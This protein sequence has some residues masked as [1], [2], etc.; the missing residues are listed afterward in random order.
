M[1]MFSVNSVSFLTSTGL[2]SWLEIIPR[3]INQSLVLITRC[4]IIPW[5][6]W[7]PE[8]CGRNVFEQRW[9]TS[10][11]M[12]NTQDTKPSSTEG[13]HQETRTASILSNQP[14]SF[15]LFSLPRNFTLNFFSHF[16]LN[17]SKSN[18]ALNNIY[19]YFLRILEQDTFISPFLFP[20]LCGS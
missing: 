8:A 17:I 5:S 7:E 2:H 14:S 15:L 12:K 13:K 10:I 9:T 1:P 11:S 6:I 20:S 16:Y 3:M 19:F 18:I 4:T